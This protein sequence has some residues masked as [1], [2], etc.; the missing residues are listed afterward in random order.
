M[1]YQICLRGQLDQTWS[2]WFAGLEIV[3]LANGDTLLVGVIP[4]Q[5]A[6]YG[7]IKKVRDL[8]MPLISLMP[9]HSTTSPF[10]SNPNEH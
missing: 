5:A 3:A 9:L 6:L 1:I 4:D 10:N 8:G 7:L 2:E